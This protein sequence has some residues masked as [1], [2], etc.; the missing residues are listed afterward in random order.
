M[1]AFQ[2]ATHWRDRTLDGMEND[3]PPPKRRRLTESG[4][5]G[6]ASVP[7]TLGWGWVSE[8]SLAPEGVHET[9]IPTYPTIF[10]QGYWPRPQ[11]NPSA[12]RPDYPVVLGAHP[13]RYGQSAT[14]NAPEGYGTYSPQE[15]DWQGVNQGEASMASRTGHVPPQIT[16]TS[17]EMHRYYTH[18]PQPASSTSWDVMRSTPSGPQYEYLDAFTRACQQSQGNF[19]PYVDAPV[20]RSNPSFGARTSMPPPARPPA[21][22]ARARQILANF[23]QHLESSMDRLQAGNLAVAADNLLEASTLLL[24]NTTE[25]STFPLSASKFRLALPS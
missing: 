25:L 19:A 3:P 7:T 24:E 10:T 15:I 20:L 18:V 16:G 2:S 14:E 11:E 17:P 23:D 6:A 9:A 4:R 22:P 13:S 21:D 5:I 12:Y 8:S 1:L